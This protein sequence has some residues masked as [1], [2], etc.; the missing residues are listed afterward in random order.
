[1]NFAKPTATLIAAATVML[2]GCASIV[3]SGNREIP[4]ASNPPGAKVTIFN[5]DNLQVAANTTPFVANLDPKYGYFKGQTYRVVF[6]MPGYYR[7][8]VNL[9][10]TLSGWYFGNIVFG[11]LIG[12]LIVD[13]ITGSMYNL[14]PNK[15]EQRLS[16]AQAEVIKD[17]K[18]FLVVMVSQTTEAE[19]LAMVKV[20]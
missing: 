15:I 13:P 9:K 17:G 1:M 18:G 4:V 7:T 2:S 10:P 20:N 3:H 11:G 12:M 16:T 6:D 5:R 8:E 14:S 19:R